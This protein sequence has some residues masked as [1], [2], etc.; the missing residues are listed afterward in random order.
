MNRLHPTRHHLTRLDKTRHDKTGFDPIRPD[1]NLKETEKRLMKQFGEGA[2]IRLSDPALANVEFVPSGILTLDLAL[3]GGFPKRRIAEIYGPPGSGKSTLAQLLI[4][5]GQKR[6]N[7]AAFIDAEHSLDV[8]YARA[9]GVDVDNLLVNQPGCGEEALE[10][11]EALISSGEVGIVVVDSVAALT[12]KAEI[13]GSVGDVYMGLAARM[14]SQAMR[15]LTATVHNS[16]AILLFINQIRYKIGVM[17]GSPETTTGGESL[18]FASGVRI[19]V[20]RVEAIKIGEETVGAVTK[21]KIVKNKVA[22][23]FREARFD[24]IYGK[25]CPRE[26]GLID[27]GVQYGLVEKAGAWITLPDG[28]RFQGRDNASNYL[29]EHVEVADKLEASI[30]ATAKS[31][32]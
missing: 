15:K 26:G 3:G 9:L 12:P 29:R 17:F 16:N 6:G 8:D 4:A 13:E 18:K 23:P 1:M 24:I 21:A 28:E 5:Q 22:P 11:T 19:D 31:G 7:V 27:L 25:G 10:I 30:R 2:L 20:R 32:K 14:M